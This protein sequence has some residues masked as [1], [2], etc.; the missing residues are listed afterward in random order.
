VAKDVDIKIFDA[1]KDGFNLSVK[2]ALV[3][4]GGEKKLAIVEKSLPPQ[5]QSVLNAKGMEELVLPSGETRRGIIEK[6]LTAMSIP[7][8]Q[9]VFSFAYPSDNAPARQI[10]SFSAIKLLRETSPCYLVNFDMDPGM[11]CLLAET[12][13][14]RILRY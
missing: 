9:G 11:Q 6:I 12:R 10:L 5:F 1:Q 7:S 14:V 13:G 8:A 4:E 2:A 3:V